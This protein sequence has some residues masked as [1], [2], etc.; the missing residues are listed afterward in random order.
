[1]KISIDGNIGVGKSTL[2]EKLQYELTR[3][4]IESD[5]YKNIVWGKATLYKEYI[6]RELLQ[7]FYDLQK[8]KNEILST[9]DNA[10]GNINKN[11]IFNSYKK[12]LQEIEEIELMHQKCFR[13]MSMKR[14]LL[15]KHDDSDYQ[16]FD[17][18]NVTNVE[19]FAKMNLSESNYIDY[20]AEHMKDLIR[21]N[22]EK[23]DISIILICNH[24]V[25]IERIDERG[26]DS[27][28]DIDEDYI[29]ELEKRHRSKGFK[30][31]LE[32]QSDKVIYIDVT[33]KDEE[34]VLEEV[35]KEIK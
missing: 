27:E 16:I 2:C 10:M 19:I 13:T 12:R 20:K 24:D 4:Y 30:K 23:Y 26:R 14:D 11:I 18:S 6:D 25:N 15:S 35:L 33:D 31:A 3:E 5:K 21:F 29:R 32:Y 9:I 7:L 1:M 34:E 28:E 22:L 8:E 17:R